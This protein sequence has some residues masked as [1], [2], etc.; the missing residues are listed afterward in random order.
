MSQAGAILGRQV[1]PCL[2]LGC[3]PAWEVAGNLSRWVPSYGLGAEYTTPG[4]SALL[5]W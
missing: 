2:A 4:L 1:C 3:G 5:C